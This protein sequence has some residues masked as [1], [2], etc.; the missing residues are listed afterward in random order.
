[1]Q[2]IAQPIDLIWDTTAKVI[3]AL[4]EQGY[5]R[6]LCGGATG[7]DALAASCVLQLRTEKQDVLLCLAIPCRDQSRG[8]SGSDLGLYQQHLQEA[9][10]VFLLSP[11]YYAGCMLVRDRFM[12]D[13]AGF[14]V[15]YMEEPT[16]GTAFTVRCAVRKGI[17]VLNIAIPEEV[18]LFLKGDA[19]VEEDLPF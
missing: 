16:G 6:F 17:P 5:R 3:R 13:H 10:H 9:D 14:C 19:P 18:S 2:H 15:A 1:M 8:W 12:V 4:Y 11:H 7:F